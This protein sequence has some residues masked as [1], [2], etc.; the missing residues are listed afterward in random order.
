M[1]ARMTT[2]AGSQLYTLF[3]S[4][5]YGEHL[6]ELTIPKAGFNAYTFTFG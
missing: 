5:D 6:L 4:D 1:A 3:D 2:I